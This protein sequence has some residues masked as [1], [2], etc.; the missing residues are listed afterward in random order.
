MHKIGFIGAG[1][2]AEAIIRSML[3][4]KKIKPEQIMASNRTS[5][6]LDRLV[7]LYGITAAKNNEELVENSEI[8]FLAT[9]PQDLYEALEPLNS[10]F[11]STQILVSL[12][13][14]VRINALKRI[15]PQCKSI[16]RVMPNTPVQIGRAVVGYCMAPG[17]EYLEFKITELLEPLGYLVKVTEGDM[18]EGLT[19]ACA[20]GPGFIFELMEYWMEWLE[21]HGFEP[22]DAR[23]MTVETFLGAALLAENSPDIQIDELQRK[24]VSKKGVT[25]AGLNSMR[26]LELE[27]GLRISF[28]KAAMRERELGDKFAQP[29]RV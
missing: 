7:K 20:S 9:K 26:E 27:R 5:G 18:L 8:I 11:D 24:V 23:K 14:G 21:E 2:L 10:V 17:I 12:A 22:K 29:Q 3:N 1:N 19:V 25:E 16:V 6:R 4:A 15:V 28:E 13:A